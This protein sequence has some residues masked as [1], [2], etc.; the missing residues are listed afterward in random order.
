M[1]SIAIVILNWNGL[2]YLQQFLPSV[3]AN[4]KVEGFIV[5]VI[6][7]DNGSTDGSVQWLS[8]LGEG[9]KI[10]Q[11]DKNYGFTGG[12]NRALKQIN[13]DYYV[14]L[15]SDV[16]VNSYWLEP[17]VSFIEQNPNVAAC[18][19]KI[20]SYAS[21]T[22][23]EYAGASGGYIDYLGYP[24]CRGRVLNIVEEDNGQYNEAK[25]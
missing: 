20:N 21:P 9:V 10:I 15:N 13:S 22:F 23:F 17:M 8:S 16:E 25:E 14:I 7:A 6:V 19:P 3:M 18:M 2:N 1:K 11:L 12:Y 5:D 24:F 4:S